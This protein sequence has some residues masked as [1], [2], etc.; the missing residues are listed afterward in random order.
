M[1]KKD[2]D[3][4]EN[5]QGRKSS[6][7][8]FELIDFTLNRH[9]PDGR[10]VAG[11]YGVNVVKVREVI[12]M[13]IINPLASNV[14]GIE[15]IFEL[16][17]VP[18]PAVNLCT[19]LGDK[20]GDLSSDDQIIVTE[21]SHKRAGFI[22]HSTNRIRRVTWDKI[23]P[24]S[25]DRASSMTGMMLIE[26]NEFLFILDLERIIAN[27]EAQA[28][29]RSAVNSMSSGAIHEESSALTSMVTPAR[30]PGYPSILIV[31]DSSLILTNLSRTL[32]QEGYGVVIARNGLEGLQRLE[33]SQTGAFRIDCI[34]TDLE[35][36]Q[37]DGLTF[38]KRVRQDPFF[39]RVPMF[40]HSS[41]SDNSS[42]E[43]AVRDGAN[44][45]FVKND[46]SVIIQTLKA[47][48]LTRKIP[49]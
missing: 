41:L 24:P 12:H 10:V 44:G 7:S 13:P 47:Q 14:P 6:G 32:N 4:N 9:L 18:I 30:R 46:M 11:T 22:V 36:P 33:E 28:Y 5:G 2:A 35:M 16:R 15:G 43:R 8:H 38:L 26:N 40:L 27:L 31:D 23:L 34:I 1:Y 39:N 3:A 49:A 37:M 42:Q 25:T 20:R 48:L 17:G 21:F 45:F 29:G 19:I